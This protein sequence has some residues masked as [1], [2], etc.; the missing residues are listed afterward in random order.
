MDDSQCI[1]LTKP[2]LPQTYLCL[3]D[4]CMSWLLNELISCSIRESKYKPSD[5]L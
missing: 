2:R 5:I 4:V 1:A 3:E